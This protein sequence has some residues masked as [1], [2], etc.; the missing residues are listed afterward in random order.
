M[1]HRDILDIYPAHAQEE[2][3]RATDLRL[4]TE[5]RGTHNMA[6]MEL[7]KNGSQA[8]TKSQGVYPIKAAKNNIADVLDVVN[9]PHPGILPERAGVPI[10]CGLWQNRRKAGRAG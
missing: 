5:P 10:V 4:S 8:D 7:Q 2:Q 6:A 9:C 3:Q 1:D